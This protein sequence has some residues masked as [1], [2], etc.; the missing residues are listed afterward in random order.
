MPTWSKP[1]LGQQ[2]RYAAVVVRGAAAE[3]LPRTVS[4]A[5]LERN[6]DAGSGAA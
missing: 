2:P 1:A 3:E 5:A 4:V 6:A